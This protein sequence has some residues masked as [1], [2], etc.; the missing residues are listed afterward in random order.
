MRKLRGEVGRKRINKAR[1]NGKRDLKALVGLG[2][3]LRDFG[4]GFAYFCF[5]EFG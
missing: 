3:D 2:I 1:V 4:G 5:Q